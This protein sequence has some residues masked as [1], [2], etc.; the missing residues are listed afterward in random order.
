MLFRCK[1]GVKSECKVLN[2]M[3][4]RI[5]SSLGW[6]LGL[7]RSEVAIGTR[8]GRQSR[9]SRLKSFRFW[10]RGFQGL[11]GGPGWQ[12]RAAQLFPPE[13]KKQRASRRPEERGMASAVGRATFVARSGLR[14][15]AS[16]SS[17]ANTLARVASD[18][19]T[20]TPGF[21][22]ANPIHF[23][24]V[25]TKVERSAFRSFA[26]EA[27]PVSAGGKGAITQVSAAF[28][29]RAQPPRAFESLLPR[30]I[31]LFVY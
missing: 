10:G 29:C 27:E 25:E 16:L 8:S 4:L 23:D 21:F 28:R 12:K 9:E 19:S 11:V 17:G 22:N 5:F 15:L 7:L 30:A 26:A 6:R 14:C 18:P 1:S 20:K 13:S 24:N 3:M 2:P 31:F